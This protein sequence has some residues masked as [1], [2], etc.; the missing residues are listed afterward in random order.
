[1]TDITLPNGG[2]LHVPLSLAEWDDMLDGL[3]PNDW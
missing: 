3:C 1:M 2:V